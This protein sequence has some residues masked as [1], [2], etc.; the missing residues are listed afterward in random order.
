MYELI[1]QRHCCAAVHIIVAIDEDS[2]LSSHG[3]V[4]AVHCQV[5]ILHEERIDEV[6]Q[7][8]MEESL[9]R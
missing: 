7:L 6:C 4:E 9:G 1:H 5:H 3:V 8:R 2:L